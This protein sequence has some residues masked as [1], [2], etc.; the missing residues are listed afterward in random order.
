ML[1][2]WQKEN[3]ELALCAIE[4]L[5]NNGYDISEKAIT[6]GL[7]NVFWTC[8]MQLFKNKNIL[9]DGTHNPDGARVLRKSLDYYFPNKKRVWVYGSLTTKDY[10][11]VMETLFESQDEVYF[12]NFE[13]PNAADF[14]ALSSNYKHC[15]PLNLKDLDYL[16]HEN[17]EALIIIC[18]SFY[19]LGQILEKSYFFNSMNNQ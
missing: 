10:P 4:V 17:K 16:L 1:G 6:Q 13:Y 8:R 7:K 12:Y 3:L 5:N 9:L 19:M 15:A 11:K 14:R 2:L 18:G